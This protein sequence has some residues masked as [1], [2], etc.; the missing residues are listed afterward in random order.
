MSN[1]PPEGIRILPVRGLPEVAPGN[2]LAG[3]IA[4]VTELVDGDVLVVTQ[5]WSPR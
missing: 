1:S 5:K 2:D 3:M 4:G